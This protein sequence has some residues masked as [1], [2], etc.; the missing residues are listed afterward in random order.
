MSNDVIIVGA[1]IVGCTTAYFLASQGV[2]VT[3]VDP[4]GIA[5]GAS[6]RNNGLIEH[7]YDAGSAALF[8]ETVP[9]LREFLGS[10][11]P[12][13]PVGALLLA[14]QEAAVR[15]LVE[16]YAQFPDL[17]PA[18]LEPDEA[19]REEPLL[20]EGLWGCMLRT[21]YPI[22]P[23]EATTAVADRARRAGA[24]FLLG[25]PVANPPA[26]WWWQR[27]PRLPTCSP[28]WCRRTSSSHSGG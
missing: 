3:V 28:G 7:P 27:G 12:E 26:M 21:G 18:L 6:G 25:E 13:E 16:H 17:S 1:G 2:G 22:S 10:A 20:A 19:R 24:E 4:V 8:D 9:L 11:M 5:A 14:D 23:L 15:E